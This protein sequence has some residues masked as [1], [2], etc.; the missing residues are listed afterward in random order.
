[1]GH[2]KQTTDTNVVTLT[3][4]QVPLTYSLI[5]IVCVGKWGGFIEKQTGLLRGGIS[6]YMRLPDSGNI[7]A[8]AARREGWLLDPLSILTLL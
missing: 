6:Q 1:M 2:A 5:T 7:L 3:V 8:E 4:N